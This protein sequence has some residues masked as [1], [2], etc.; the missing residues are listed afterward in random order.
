MSRV[1][2]TLI[3]AVPTVF[4]RSLH[5]A[6]I[7]TQLAIV[8]KKVVLKYFFFNFYFGSTCAPVRDS[9]V[10][11]TFFSFRLTVYSFHCWAAGIFT[12]VIGLPP[13]FVVQLCS[14][15]NFFTI[16]IVAQ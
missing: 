8:V 15:L 1:F 9:V 6:N 12:T 10:Y 5:L 7:Q 11:V 13:H 3:L 2:T 14:N 4:S 16:S